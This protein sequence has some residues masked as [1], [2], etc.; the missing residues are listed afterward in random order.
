MVK[1]LNLN[2]NNNDSDYLFCWSKFEDRPNQITLVGHFDVSKFFDIISGEYCGVTTDV[3]L[4]LENILVNERSLIKISDGVYIAYSQYDKESEKSIIGDVLIYYNNSSSIESNEL[5]QKLND[6]TYSYIEDSDLN[7]NTLFL[8]TNGIEV[9]PLDLSELDED[10]IESYYN[11]DVNKK[12]K[13][14]IKSIKRQNKGLSIIF[15]DRGCG[16]TSLINYIVSNLE[17]NVIFIPLTMVDVTINS[18][19]F[20]NLVRR[21]KNSVF[22]IDDC[23][24]IFS[25]PFRKPSS[26]VNNILQLIDGYQSDVFSINII[27]S[28]NINNIDQI[29]DSILDCNNIIDVI[30]VSDLEVDKIK[31]LSKLLGNKP[32]QKNN[33]RLIDVINKDWSSSRY[34]DIGFS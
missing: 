4:N 5:A 1:N 14:L 9:E 15:G 13:K 18:P 22:V 19:D 21:Y 33:M 16:K 26:F 30:E 34:S 2:I 23:E 32:K 6:A 10:N 27:L 17:K 29:D 20:L 12:T 11:D 24:M 28:M 3:I 7:I 8:S 31:E 25:D